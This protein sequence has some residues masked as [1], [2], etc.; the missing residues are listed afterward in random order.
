MSDLLAQF[1]PTLQSLK[2]L[3]NRGQ[4]L[5]T[6]VTQLRHL[7]QQAHST[8]GQQSSPL[9]P[10]CEAVLAKFASTRS[11]LDEAY[12]RLGHGLQAYRQRVAQLEQ[13]CTTQCKALF[14]A[15]EELHQENARLLQAAQDTQEATRSQVFQHGI[16]AQ[17]VLQ[18][19][20]PQ[21]VAMD[22]TLVQ[23]VI[24]GTQAEGLKLATQVTGVGRRLEGTILPQMVE[25]TDRLGGSLQ[26]GAQQVADHSQKMAR[27]LEQRIEDLM[28]QAMEAT[29]KLHDESNS[30]ILRLA[31]L[32]PQ[33]VEAV[34][35]LLAEIRRAMKGLHKA[36][37]RA[38]GVLETILEIV[39]GL[40]QVLRNIEAA[41]K[42]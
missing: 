29:R 16:E 34:F 18:Q 37:R 13:T 11:G 1:Q 15:V 24:P 42:K 31:G 36:K 39:D 2:A 20:A 32:I 21:V 14:A 27:E 8:F 38:T 7:T 30:R 41:S 6:Q 33:D 5:S 17:S 40:I 28:K 26:T 9:L 23:K 22:E 12:G 19:V 3:G 10:R 25:A 4:E 35:L